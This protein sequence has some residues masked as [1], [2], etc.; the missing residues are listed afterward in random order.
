MNPYIDSVMHTYLY[1]TIIE[2]DFLCNIFQNQ[3]LV[4][5]KESLKQ[6]IRGEKDLIDARIDRNHAFFY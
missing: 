4:E 3:D 6:K 1:L 5:E 2:K